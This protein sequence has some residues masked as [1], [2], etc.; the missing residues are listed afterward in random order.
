MD[1][2]AEQYDSHELSEVLKAVDDAEHDLQSL[3]R[4]SSLRQLDGKLADLQNCSLAC[5]FV[6]DQEEFKR[7]RVLR[8]LA[9]CDNENFEELATLSISPGGFAD[10]ETRKIACVY[11]NS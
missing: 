10:D 6:D 2:K 4:G 7:K 5:D 9:A 8:V 11:T 3:N 1:E